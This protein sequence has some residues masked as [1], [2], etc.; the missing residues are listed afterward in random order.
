MR[1]VIDTSVLVAGLRSRTG[2]S[3]ALIEQIREETMHPVAS[4][5]LFLEYEEVLKREKHGLD[6]DM[7]EDFLKDLI[8]AI[9][10]VRIRFRW[11]PLLSDPG[12]EMVIEAAINARVSAIVTHNKR[13]FESAA[14]RF[15][16][17]VLSPAQML[18]MLR[19]KR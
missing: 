17:A 15:G 9:E 7:V 16:I 5:A 19:L 13:D 12:D 14:A 1:C 8:P 2:A 10:P 18:E 4:P 6:P 3:F 11:R